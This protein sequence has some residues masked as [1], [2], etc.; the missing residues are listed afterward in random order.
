V[1]AALT[2]SLPVMVKALEAL[3]QVKDLPIEAHLSPEQWRLV[4]IAHN[5][6]D[7]QV[8]P[9]LFATKV[10]VAIERGSQIA[11]AM[12]VRLPVRSMS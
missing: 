2:V 7:A 10:E 11:E 12:G 4:S 5:M 3:R 8:Q 6:L 1:T 9:I